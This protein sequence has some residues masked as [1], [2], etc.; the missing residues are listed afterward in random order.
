MKKKFS[1]DCCGACCRQLFLFGSAYNWLDDGTGC[2]RYF[3]MSTNLCT[4][5][6][7]RPLICRVEEGY[8]LFFSHISWDEYIDQ[9]M[10]ACELLKKHLKKK[11]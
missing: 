2:C 6:F 11:I 1:C 7:L 10:Y 4:V 5:Y 3:D 9:S 8:Y